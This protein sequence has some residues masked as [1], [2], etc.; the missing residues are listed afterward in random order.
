MIA[1]AN[2]SFEKE[3]AVRE[4]AFAGI[5][6]LVL[7]GLAAGQFGCIDAQDKIVPVIADFTVSPRMGRM[8]LVVH[9]ADRSTGH[10]SS[11]EW[12]FENDGITDAATREATWMYTECGEYNVCLTVTG[13]AGSDARVISRCVSVYEGIVYVDAESGNDANSGIGW[14]RAVRTIQKG[15]DLADANWSVLVA[16]GVYTGDGNFDLDF[17]GRAIHLKSAGG[18]LECIID[19]DRKGHGIH[20][21]SGEGENSVV[22]GL[23]I[24][25]GF[26]GIGSEEPPRGGA[27]CCE[28]SSNPAIRQC[29][30]TGNYA[31][32][33]GGI[34]CRSSSPVIEDCTITANRGG[35]GIYCTDSN[36]DITHCTVTNNEV[37]FTGGGICCDSG[38][39]PTITNCTVSYNTAWFPMHSRGGGVFCGSQ[40]S[41][42]IANC[43][44]T[45]NQACNGGGVCCEDLS[46]A[47]FVNCTITDNQATYNGGGLCISGVS[48]FTMANCTIANNQALYRNGGGIHCLISRVTLNN[49]I[50][51]SNTA[52]TSGNEIHTFDAESSVTLNYCCVDNALDPNNIT[53]DGTVS[54]DANCITADPMFVDPGGTN[55]RL[56]AGSPCIDAGCN[57]LVRYDYDLDGNIRL[58]DGGVNGTVTVDMGAYELQRGN[59][60]PLV[61][62]QNAPK[63]VIQDDTPAF[64]FTGSDIDGEVAGYW[65]S[66]DVEPPDVFTTDTV[67]I[68]QPVSGGAHT[69][70]VQAQ[71]DLGTRSI[72]KS[73]VFSYDLTPSVLNVPVEYLTIQE[74]IDF[75]A[76][77]D[78]VIIADGT[79]TGNGNK[80]LDFNGKEITV[81][82]LNGPLNCIIDC[83]TW[84]R[85]FYFHSG[86]SGNSEII[87]LTVLNGGAAHGACIMC[88]YSNPTIRNCILTGN[89]TSYGGGVFCDNSS[90]VIANCIIADNSAYQ[91]GGISCKYYSCPL[92]INCV[93]VNNSACDGGGVL[94]ESYSCPTIVNCTIAFNSAAGSGYSSGG[95]IYCS[96]RCAPIFNNTVLWGNSALNMGNQI[97]AGTSD[98]TVKLNSCCYANGPGDVDWPEAIIPSNCIHLDPMFVNPG[99][100]DYR[101]Q[102][103]SPCVNA[104]NNLLVPP[105]ITEDLDGNPRI[106]GDRVDLG[107]YERQQ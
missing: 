68:S 37:D 22:E 8:P 71:D 103:G 44:I 83:E 67:W 107:A 81:K 53:G 56:Q 45:S 98:S 58:K 40:S 51:W 87:G 101:L 93:I 94:C 63:G 3:D 20:F 9:F 79:Y 47:V 75:A 50:L 61:V 92:V 21:R 6:A 43:K 10:I 99:G 2:V 89:S 42:L 64:A 52:A 33:G 60:A 25:N 7:A 70:Y 14:T 12:D 1:C 41:P 88:Y 100:Q 48:D 76:N 38:S 74:A 27:I 105:G 96:Q 49:T 90:P 29:V 34:Y 55:Y 13:P 66:I 82:S 35:G 39:N 62:I 106:V 95:G 102:A 16:D 85:A 104:G 30:I 18:A 77:G 36:P 86:E 72:T 78:T 15:L 80:N 54:P 28:N 19:C 26:L 32:F 97:Y 4:K 73:C 5:L 59:A 84:D 91:G 57:A 46:N 11:W 31:G 69:F 17:G 65:V 24:T 23:T